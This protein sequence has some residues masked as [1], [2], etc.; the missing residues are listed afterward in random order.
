MK[1]SNWLPT[2]TTLNSVTKFQFDCSHFQTAETSTSIGVNNN[3][4]SVSP[5]QT[6]TYIAHHL[7]LTMLTRSRRLSL[8]AW[9]RRQKLRQSLVRHPCPI[10][11]HAHPLFSWK[12]SIHRWNSSNSGSVKH[13]SYILVTGNVVV[14]THH[15]H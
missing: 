3:T 8:L 2:W 9:R 14:V 6:Q 4:M 12:Y 1:K 7:Q 15:L 11:H 13:A 5:T 10:Q